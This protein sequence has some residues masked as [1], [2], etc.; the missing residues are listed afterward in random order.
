MILADPFHPAVR[1]AAAYAASL[2]G[3]NQRTPART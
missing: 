3:R 1:V 2:L